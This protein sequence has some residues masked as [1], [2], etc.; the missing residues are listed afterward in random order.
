MGG[1]G[2][3]EGERDGGRLIEAE[4]GRNRERNT[5][6]LSRWPD[7]VLIHHHSYAGVGEKIKDSLLELGTR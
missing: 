7:I 2:Q 3:R 4:R 6:E 1:G 5:R